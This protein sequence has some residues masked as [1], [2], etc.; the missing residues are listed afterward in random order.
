MTS[1]IVMAPGWEDHLYAATDR[2][3]QVKLGPAIA[4]DAERLAPKGET[5]RLERDIGH[6]LEGHNLIVEDTAPYTAWVELGHQIAHGP[7]MR[8]V[9]PKMK[10]PHPFLRPATFRERSE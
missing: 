8:E 9:G 5:G 3:F 10:A 7:H 2:L 6:H 4:S 1:R